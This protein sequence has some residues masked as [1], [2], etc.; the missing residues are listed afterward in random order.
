MW[1]AAGA[2]SSR[3]EGEVQPRVELISARGV[4]GATPSDKRIVLDVATP[5]VLRGEGELS[6]IL[7][8]TAG[9]AG[10]LLPSKREV[11]GGRQ[12]VWF[13]LLDAKLGDAVLK[14]RE[15]SFLVTI[16]HSL[17]RYT[18]LAG[19]PAESRARGETIERLL[20]RAGG[21][22][23]VALLVERARLS[24]RTGTAEETVARWMELAKE[25]ALAGD[26]SM[27]SNG[28]RAAAYFAYFHRRDFAPGDRALEQA[29]E[30]D[31]RFEFVAGMVKNG[32]QAGLAAQER[33]R[34]REAEVL[35]R[36]AYQRGWSH[37]LDREAAFAMKALGPLLQDQGRH[38]EALE[39]LDLAGPIFESS[40]EPREQ[41]WYENDLAWVLLRGGRENAFVLDEQR[42]RALEMRALER[43][44]KLELKEEQ[45]S[46]L[47]N[48]AWLEQLLGR[49]DEARALAENARALA[50]DRRSFSSL[51]LTLLEGSLAF[52]AGELD[53]A[54]QLYSSAEEIAGV[55]TPGGTSD[56][57]WRARHG[58]A[59]VAEAKKQKQR[60]GALYVSAVD[61][62]E[63]SA[64]AAGFEGGRATYLGDRREL[65][66]DALRFF[67]REGRLEL[68]F[69]ISSRFRAHLYRVMELE[70]ARARLD[71]GLSAEL[72]KVEREYQDARRREESAA[73]AVSLAA[74]NELEAKKAEL[75]AIRSEARA[76]V[77]RRIELLAGKLQPISAAAIQNALG[78][79]EVLF[80]FAR[81]GDQVRIFAVTKKRVELII[82]TA[83]SAAAAA[84]AN[85][86]EHTTH[87][88]VV[89]GDAD[90]AFDLADENLIQRST[91][92]HLPHAGVIRERNNPPDE[93]LIRRSTISHLPHAGV[94][95]ERNNPPDE[96]LIRRSTISQ[97]PHAG[98]IRERNQPPAGAPLFAGDPAAN[99]PHARTEATEL[100][101]RFPGSV[102]WLG[103]DVRR[104]KLL[105]A[106]DGRALFHFAGHGRLD[107]AF[108][109]HLELAAG[110]TLRISDVFARRAKIGLVVLSGCEMG[111]MSRLG[112][113]HAVALPESFFVAGAHAVLAATSKIKDLEARDFVLEFYA[114]GGA[115]APIEA[116]AHAARNQIASQKTTWRSFRVVGLK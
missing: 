37:G 104:E 6:P 35:L 109:A 107:G 60:A 40:K 41:L 76:A 9:R 62:L 54:E 22:F 77:D 8:S 58:R 95:R 10:V 64:L 70:D 66:A 36:D 84:R 99:L 4:R 48:L 82:A 83:E 113:S 53:T 69:E 61:A 103:E 17:A 108:D 75:A 110:E 33:G 85:L 45:A 67:E 101:S 106:I 29:L 12:L 87:V 56:A 81:E 73:R 42:I 72:A 38:R 32:L 46:I 80:D 20:M 112:P 14:I 26:P 3:D 71:A 18:E 27:S 63:R 105:D 47:A 43:A 90:A 111:A 13:E 7:T 115:Q 52:E 44:R 2:C 51:F 59:R 57:I 78:A 114:E 74:K 88:Y 39:A 21:S 102:L 91:I 16:D 25:A 94:I 92:S 50:P 5:V 34:L 49:R 89:A 55:E 86:A 68:A 98:V 31:Q 15:Q 97:L 65:L 24:Q 100:S 93:N 79:H 19:L 116:Y 1:C 28:L 96:N 23:R 30:L 11:R